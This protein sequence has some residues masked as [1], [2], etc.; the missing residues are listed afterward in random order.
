MS[1]VILLGF[2]SLLS[3]RRISITILYLLISHSE[4]EQNK[5]GTELRL[6]TFFAFIINAYFLFYCEL[7]METY[8][9]LLPIPNSLIISGVQNTNNLK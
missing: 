4:Y 8:L 3:K 2:L 5:Y 9:N 1:V 7:K 6:L